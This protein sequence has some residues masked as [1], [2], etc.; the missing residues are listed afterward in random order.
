MET[1]LPIPRAS[2]V[3]NTSSGRRAGTGEA[4][5]RTQRA[6]LEGRAPSPGLL[7]SQWHLNEEGI[8]CFHSTEVQVWA[9]SAGHA[10]VE[11][12]TTPDRALTWRSLQ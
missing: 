2:A 9:S 6:I 1:S 12:F 10:T 7:I 3:W 5:N 11:A 8:P 4:L